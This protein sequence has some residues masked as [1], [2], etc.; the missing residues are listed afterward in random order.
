MGAPRQSEGF[1]IESYFT[2]SLKL[3]DNR[4]VAMLGIPINVIL[5]VSSTMAEVSFVH[6]FP[7]APAVIGGSV[8]FNWPTFIF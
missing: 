3:E 7:S 8:G 6:G 4:L 1:S 5:F 2:S